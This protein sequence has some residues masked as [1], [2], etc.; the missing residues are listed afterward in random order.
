MPQ[1]AIAAEMINQLRLPLHHVHSFN[2]DEYADE[3]G[4][5]A[6]LDWPGSFQAAMWA[7]FFGRI[8]A[9]LRPILSNVACEHIPEGSLAIPQALAMIPFFR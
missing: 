7:N 5:T 8:D 1:Y 2:M 6:P 3:D 9:K 4:N